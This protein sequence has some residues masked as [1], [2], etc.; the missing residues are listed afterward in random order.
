AR[1]MLKQ[2]LGD[3]VY[4]PL[5]TFMG[6]LA[7]IGLLAMAGLI[8]LDG[9]LEVPSAIAQMTALVS[10]YWPLE[11]FLENRRF[12]RRGRESA[13]ILFKFLDRPGE[14]GQAIGADSLPSMSRQLEFDG[15]SLREPGT[16]R[17]LLQG[18]TLSIQAGQRV[19]IVGPDEMEK[20]AL[21]YLIP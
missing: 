1:S 8:V 18:V 17:M 15:V 9:G 10:L 11:S 14:V 4:W 12:V 16:G 13:E 6:M 7:S 2:Q 19:C 5:L 21:M 3:A 20:H